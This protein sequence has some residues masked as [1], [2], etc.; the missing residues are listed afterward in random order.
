MRGLIG[1]FLL[2]VEA[3]A[4]T[5]GDGMGRTYAEKLK[6][7]RWQRRRLEILEAG[8]WKCSECGDAK[9]TLHVHHGTYVKGR[10]PWDYPDDF[11]RVLCESCHGEMEL[12]LLSL[13]CNVAL[14]SL[15]KTRA[16]ASVAT[17]LLNV[18]DNDADHIERASCLSLGHAIA[19]ICRFANESVETDRAVVE[20][21]RDRSEAANNG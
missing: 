11:L 7:P 4:D 6:D 10:D 12:A 21:L 9:S 20:M 14:L 16:L 17:A 2:V 5:E 8:G 1:L 13:G 3:P 18:D 15:P 19:A